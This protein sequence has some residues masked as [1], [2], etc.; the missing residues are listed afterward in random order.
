MEQMQD[1]ETNKKEI[2]ARK[3]IEDIKAFY[4]HLFAYCL[5]SPFMIFINYKT[6]WD[7]KWFWFPIL[8]WGIGVTIH[9]F[10]VFVHKGTL[11]RNWEE[12]KIEE[13]MRKDENKW[14]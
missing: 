2:R 6:Y 12:R 3:H 9:A 13:L 7:Y 5:F 4:Q 11:G 1:T 14:N 10:V 8:G